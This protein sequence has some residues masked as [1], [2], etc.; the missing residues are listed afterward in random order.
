VFVMDNDEPQ[1]R[2]TPVEGSFV[3]EQDDLRGQADAAQR[4]QVL[5]EYEASTPFDLVNGPLLRARLVRMGDEHSVLLLTLHHIA[6]DGWSMG[7][8]S[9]EM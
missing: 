6:S 7:V 1:L 4:L 3:L 5:T 2:I 9:R 8:L